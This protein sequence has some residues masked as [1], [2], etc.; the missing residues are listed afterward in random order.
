MT[1]INRQARPMPFNRFLLG[2]KCLIPCLALICSAC[3]SDNN[4]TIFGYTT[5]PNYDCGIKTIRVPIFQNLS[6]YRDIEFELTTAVVREIETRTPYKVV[7]LGSSADTELDCKIVGL[8]KQL[9]NRNQLNEVREAE[10]ILTVDVT[11]RDLRSGEI[12]SKP[13]TNRNQQIL[14]PTLDGGA[15]PVV[16]PPPPAGVIVQSSATF[17]PEIGQSITTARQKAV[18]RLAR[19][20]V[21][22]M[23]IPW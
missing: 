10:M 1:L 20:I 21:S 12:L 14:L 22:M 6:A 16:P 3:E 23:E 13:Q 7:G 15:V 17:I 9:L 18:N 11:W 2:L 4:F 8:N 5:K 19:D